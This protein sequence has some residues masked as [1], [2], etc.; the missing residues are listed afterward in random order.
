MT[1][2]GLV[3]VRN[4]SALFLSERGQP[5]PGSVVFAGIEGSRP[6]LCEFQA[7]VAPSPAFPARAGRWCGLG[8]RGGCR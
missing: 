2:R 7:L 3:E 4:P 8:W 6:M 1:G 5:A